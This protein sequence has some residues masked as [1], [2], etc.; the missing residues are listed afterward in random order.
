MLREEI[1]KLL[2]REP[3]SF[4]IRVKDKSGI[5]AVEVRIEDKTIDCAVGF[6]KELSKDASLGVSLPTI[7]AEG[8]HADR[9]SYDW[10]HYVVPELALNEER[11][12]ALN[13][14]VQNA[15]GTVSAR[16]VY[17]ELPPSGEIDIEEKSKHIFWHVS[18]ARTKIT[19]SVQIKVEPM[20]QKEIEIRKRRTLRD[21]TGIISAPADAVELKKKIQRGMK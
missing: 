5:K 17:S 15:S 19:N 6:P 18:E 12:T 7:S 20:E 9:V 10:H 11:K 2:G 8:S 3:K 14:V 13:D 1:R 16:T 21:I 4:D